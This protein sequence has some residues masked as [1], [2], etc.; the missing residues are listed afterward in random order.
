MWKFLIILLFALPI[1]GLYFSIKKSQSEQRPGFHQFSM[2]ELDEKVRKRFLM[3]MK[4]N[5]YFLNDEKQLSCFMF[6]YEMTPYIFIGKKHTDNKAI[7]IHKGESQF[8]KG[9]T[10]HYSYTEETQKEPLIIGDKSFT[11][12][13]VRADN[14]MLNGDNIEVQLKEVI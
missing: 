9:I 10:L 5:K 4:V 14:C 1:I 3:M 6:S 8:F 11:Y 2:D 12:T 13:I 7:M